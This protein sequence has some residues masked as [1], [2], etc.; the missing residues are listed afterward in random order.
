MGPSPLFGSLAEEATRRVQ[1]GHLIW[2]GRTPKKKKNVRISQLPA[3]IYCEESMLGEACLLGSRTC[4]ESSN[5]RHTAMN[6]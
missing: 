4:R 6:E 5:A 2:V 3:T 1:F